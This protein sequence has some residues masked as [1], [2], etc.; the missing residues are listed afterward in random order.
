MCG[1]WLFNSCTEDD[2]TTKP[3][4]REL[5]ETFYQ[6]DEQMILA[7]NGAY[8][9]FQHVIWGG[10]TFMWGS[11]TSDDAIAGGGDLTD[12]KGYQVADR[13][14]A[15]PVEDKDL[16]LKDFYAL[17]FRM[18]TRANAII[19]YA[20]E[21]TQLGSLAVANAYFLK[22]MAYFQLTRMFGRL[23]IIDEVP[24]ISS[25]YARAATVEETWAATEGYLQKAIEMTT[26][27]K[28]LGVRK[29][30]K[31]P[32]DGYATLGAAQALLGKV[33]MYQGKYTEAIEVL[34]AIYNSGEY[35]LETDYE[36]VFHPGN[37]HGIESIF[38][39][40]M[41]DKGA[42]SWNGPDNNGNAIATLTSPR[43]FSN[44]IKAFPDGIHMS[45]WG[46]NTPT[47]KLVAAFDAMGDE[48]RKRVSVIS[49]D[50][51]QYQ[52]DTAGIATAWENPLTGYYDN[53]HSLRVGFRISETQVN[54]NINVMRFAD[55]ILM[56]AEAHQQTGND[57]LARTYLNEVRARVELAEVTSSGADLL[58]AI[59]K[60]RQLELCLEGDRYFDLVRWGDAA[61]ELTGE[62]YDAGG[63][64]YTTGRPGVSTNG[65][66]PI[67]QDEI[68][69]YGDFNYE[70][71]AGY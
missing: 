52:C 46:M 59:K 13:F 69:A 10:S 21:T 15:D 39:I 56:L 35:A 2:L 63:L 27:G 60:E 37:P 30:Q 17:W 7:L 57:G 28:G 23:P 42:Q 11:I 71:N 16:N 41:T 53:K 43:A 9:P 50:T 40:N 48:V 6:T 8:D 68:N 1:I 44:N 54:Q 22:G 61:K 32:S 62:E 70:Q 67:P 55:V 31:D 19:T 34:T 24:D 20:D 14:L 29:G 3:D 26:G 65:L 4:G 36:Q 47:K 45:G 64:N 18:N 12:Q 33:Y 51:L 58:S 66:F 25:K 5:V 38:E 49:Q